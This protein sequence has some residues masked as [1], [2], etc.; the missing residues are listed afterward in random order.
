MAT[1]TTQ[2]IITVST[3]QPLTASQVS[4]VKKILEER[5]GQPKIVFNTDPRILGGVKIKIGNQQYDA[6]LEGQLERLQLTR[7]HC[8]LTTA[9][10][11]TSVQYKTLASAI[12]DKYGSIVI[13][14]VVDPSVIGGIKL[15]LGSKEY[16]HTIKAKLDQLHKQATISL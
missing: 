1:R 8:T 10:P 5:A 16:N 13:D 11:L 6:T 14:E 9:I 2:P 3:A 12:S 4:Q 15:M 7:D